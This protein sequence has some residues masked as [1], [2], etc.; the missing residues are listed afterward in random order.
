MPP[1]ARSLPSL[2]ILNPDIAKET[3]SRKLLGIVSDSTAR[4]CFALVTPYTG[5]NLGDGAIQEAVIWNIRSRFPNASIYGITLNPP[6][7]VERHGILSYPI[8]GFLWPGY[9]VA[10]PSRVGLPS[11]SGA[12]PSGYARV[13]SKVGK[14]LASV[15]SHIA[16]FLLPRGWRWFIRTEMTHVLKGFSFLKDVDLL[17]FSGGGQLDDGWGGAWGHPYALLK[18]AV[19]RDSGVPGRSS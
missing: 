8:S 4:P 13:R 5:G 11:S 10:S 17:I 6:D 18:W 2:S 14:C 3:A 1:F 19:L 7:T 9:K 15:P 12:Q 16:R